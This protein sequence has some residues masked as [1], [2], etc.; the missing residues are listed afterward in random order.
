MTLAGPS[1]FLDSS[2]DYLIPLFFIF[3][4]I[5]VMQGLT[6]TDETASY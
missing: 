1:Y 6:G 4:L 3:E 2:F 5:G